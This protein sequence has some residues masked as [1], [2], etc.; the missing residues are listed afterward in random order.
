LDP[1]IN[2]ISRAVHF[3]ELEGTLAIEVKEAFRHL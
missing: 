2:L 3:H 1:P